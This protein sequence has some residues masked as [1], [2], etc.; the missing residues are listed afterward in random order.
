[1][2]PKK[3]VAPPQESEQQVGAGAGRSHHFGSDDLEV[4]R[5]KSASNA[6][7][8]ACNDEGEIAHTLGVVTNEFDAFG[9]VTH[10]IEHAAQRRLG[11][12]V[13]QGHTH[14][15]VSSN[16]VVNLHLRAKSDAH[17]GLTSHPVARHAGLSAEELGEHQRHG[18]HQLGHAHGD[19]GKRCSGFLGGDI[20]QQHG[21]AHACHTAHQ[22]QQTDRDAQLASTHGVECVHG[23]VGAQARVDRMP[24][25]EHAALPQQHVVGQASNDGDAHLGQHGGRQVAGEHQRRTDEHQGKQT[26]DDPAADVIRF[27]FVN[28]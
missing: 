2:G 3:K 27:E 26:P 5:A 13:H 6:R 24:E 21:K 10:G 14:K 23:H 18:E 11:E 7:K 1:M 12:G 22:R 25:A 20:A 9:V 16:Q 19:H 28:D 15:G 4:E 8:E 17:E